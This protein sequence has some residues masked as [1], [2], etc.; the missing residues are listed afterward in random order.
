MTIVRELGAP[1]LFMT[2]MCNP[3]WV[4]IKEN[5]RQADRLDIVARVFIQK[6]NAISKDLDEGVL[7]I[8]AARIYVVEY[9]KHGLPHAHILLISR[10]EDKPLTAEDVNRLGLAELPDKEKHPHVY[11]TVVTCMLHGPCGD[12]NPNCPCMKNGKCSKKFPKHLSEETT[13][14]EEKYPN[15]KNCMRSPSELVI[16]RTFWNNAMVNQ[17]VVPYNPFLSQRYSCHINVEVC[18]T[19]KAVKYI[20][21]YV[22]KGPTRQW[23]LFKAKQTGN[24]LMRFYNIC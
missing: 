23:L 3:K 9:Q 1:N 6:L 24:H 14:P 4:E 8:Q 16:E 12:A 10:P 7:G 22:Y 13:M 20:Y 15:Y 17:W 5:L 19:T 2:Y 21:K 11:E 18:A